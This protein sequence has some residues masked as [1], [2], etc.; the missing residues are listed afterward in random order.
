MTLTVGTAQTVD[1]SL[2]F[3]DADGDTLSYTASSSD[4]SKATTSK[5]GSTITI[6]PKAVGNVTITVI[7]RDGISSA[8]QSIAVTVRS[9]PQAVGTIPAMTVSLTK[10]PES[11]NVSPYFTDA[12]GDKLNYTA[13]SSDATKATVGALGSTVSITPK[14][15]GSRDR[16]GEG[17]RS[18]QQ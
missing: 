9:A 2:Y 18:E 15:A 13:T 7:A 3:S 14:A 10:G 16:H 8:S 5:E 11:V 6:T 1:A 4:S 17:D 12:D